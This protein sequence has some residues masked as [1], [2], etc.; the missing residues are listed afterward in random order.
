MGITLSRSTRISAAGLTSAWMGTSTKWGWLALALSG[1]SSKVEVEPRY[2]AMGKLVSYVES[3]EPIQPLPS[4]YQGLDDKSFLGKQLFYDKRLSHDNTVACASCHTIA[5]GGDDGRQFSVGIGGAVGT[6]NSPTVLNAALN[7]AQFWD[8]RASNLEAQAAGPIHAPNEMGSNWEEVIAKLDA[9]PEIR[10]K[11]ERLYPSGITA[12][13][14]TECLVAYEKLLITPDAPFDRFLRG[15]VGA[16]DND[17]IEGYRLFK[18][19]GCVSCHQGRGIGGN[20]F[21]QFGVMR[22]YLD[23]TSNEA[24]FDESVHSEPSDS[25]LDTSHIKV[26]SLRNVDLTAPYLHDGSAQTLEEAIQVMSTYQ[27]GAELT[28]EDTRLLVA[29]LR[30]L[31]GVLSEELK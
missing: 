10:Q 14:I 9:D 20:L 21:A 24:A 30:S 27:L 15:E 1:C 8:G 13:A 3:A 18:E 2:M 26:P 16:V 6:V 23:K 4:I 19:M 17:V 29:F 28:E 5:L 7:L 22:A 12:A 31:N 25:A 11:F